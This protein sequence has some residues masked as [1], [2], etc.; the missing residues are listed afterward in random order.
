[1]TD[2]VERSAQSRVLPPDLVCRL[3]GVSARTLAMWQERGK[4]PATVTVGVLV[5]WLRDR[6]LAVP[7]EL[8]AKS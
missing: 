2:P 8:E 3:L 7:A 5:K 4:L 6:C 1:M